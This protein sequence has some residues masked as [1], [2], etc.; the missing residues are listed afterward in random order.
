MKILYIFLNMQ[1]YITQV[2]LYRSDR[3]KMPISLGVGTI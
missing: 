2:A 3:Y 1:L